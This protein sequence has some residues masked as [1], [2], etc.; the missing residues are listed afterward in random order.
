MIQDIFPS[1]L[2]NSFKDY[3]ARDEDILIVFDTDGKAVVAE[4]DGRMAFRTCAGVSAEDAVYLFSIDDTRFFLY[5]GTADMPAGAAVYTIREIRDRFSGKDD[6][7]IFAVFTAYHLWR[8]YADNKFCGRCGR[9]LTYGK[10]ERSLVCEACGNTVYPR[11]N[12][13]VIVGVINKDSL[14]LTKYRRGYAHNALV[15]GFTEIG[16]TLEE[17]VAREVFE[18][19]GLKVKNITYYKSQP[20]GMAQDILVGYYCEVDGDSDIHMDESEL[21]YAEWVKRED[22][23]LQPNNLSLT[24]EMMRM[25][26]DGKWSF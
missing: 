25:F 13:A 18:E 26:K 11:I 16:E 6:T 24:N 17:T 7:N 20:W 5:V 14:L 22:I 4:K 23:V 2:D 9:Q 21:K 1:K 12:P 10:T 15:A 8:W 3:T 19:T